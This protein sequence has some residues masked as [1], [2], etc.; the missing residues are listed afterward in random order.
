MRWPWKKAETTK[1][2]AVISLPHLHSRETAFAPARWVEPLSAEEA[3]KRK[4]VQ[5]V[6]EMAER[7]HGE[8][9]ASPRSAAEISGT[10]LPKSHDPRTTL[11]LLFDD[12]LR[13]NLDTVAGFASVSATLE[14]HCRRLPLKPEQDAALVFCEAE[15]ATGKRD[16]WIRRAIG[17]VFQSEISAMRAPIRAWCH[18]APEE[19][20]YLLNGVLLVECE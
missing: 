20:E 15:R 7:L 11:P 4:F 1:A 3:A 2:E 17:E 19:T 5:G 14:A 9:A 18:Y 12:T 6:M 16:P 10:E 13:N 8:S